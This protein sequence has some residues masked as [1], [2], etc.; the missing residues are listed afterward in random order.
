M[1]TPMESR[2]HV[3]MKYGTIP[4]AACGYKFTRKLPWLALVPI[5]LIQL[6]RLG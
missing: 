4:S 3:S 1:G 2:R 6:K 5:I